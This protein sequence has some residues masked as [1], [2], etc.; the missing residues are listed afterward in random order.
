MISD[1]VLCNNQWWQQ[2][3]SFII[4]LGNYFIK[5]FA[6]N[7]TVMHSYRHYAQKIASTSVARAGQNYR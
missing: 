1:I 6:A 2:A 7:Q 4:K 3:L 5:E